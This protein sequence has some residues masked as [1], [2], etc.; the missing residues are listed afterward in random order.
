MKD[1]D[2]N[3]MHVTASLSVRFK[4]PT[5]LDKPVTLRAHVKEVNDNRITVSC[6]LYSGDTI[7]ATGEVVTVGVNRDS[8]LN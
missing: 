4:R 6:T 7:C 1:A 2:E 5:P 8:F 3:I